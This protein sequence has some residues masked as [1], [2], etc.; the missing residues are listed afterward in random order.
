MM[1]LIGRVVILGLMAV[2]AVV[3]AAGVLGYLVAL[4]SVISII[5][6]AQI[7]AALALGTLFS[8]GYAAVA[9]KILGA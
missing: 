1:T 8:I 5:S 3:V 2:G 6:Y 4:A 9:R 7:M